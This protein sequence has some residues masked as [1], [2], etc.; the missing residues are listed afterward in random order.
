VALGTAHCT[1]VRREDVGA[2]VDVD[3]VDG[4]ARA[5]ADLLAAV[6]DPPAVAA[7]RAR[8]RGISLARYTWEVQ[9]RD[10]V[11]LYR[12]LAGAGAAG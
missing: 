2:C 1:L 8:I 7:R 12:R 9:Q 6:A 5:C 4:I 10:L 11:A 3:D